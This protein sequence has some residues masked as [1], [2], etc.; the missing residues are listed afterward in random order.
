MSEEEKFGGLPIYPNEYE[1]FAFCV[2]SCDLVEVNYKGSPFTW[3][4]GRIDNQCIFKRL[5]RYM[6]NNEFMGVFGMVEVEHLVRAGSDHASMLLSSGQKNNVPKRPFRFLKF[7][8]ER[9]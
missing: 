7:W 9:S 1:N 4:N 6:M 3:W 5:D 2:N 8:T